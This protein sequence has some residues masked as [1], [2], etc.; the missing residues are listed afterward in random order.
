MALLDPLVDSK[1]SVITNDGRNFVGILTGFDQATN[2]ILS[3]CYERVY[4]SENSETA[5]SETRRGLYMVRGDLV[6]LVGELDEA[7]DDQTDVSAIRCPPMVPV[8]H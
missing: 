8:K 3:E 7:I 2:L 4:S 5:S 1:V 6:A